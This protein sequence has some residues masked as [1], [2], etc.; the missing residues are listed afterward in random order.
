[1]ELKAFA[2]LATRVREGLA[3][4]PFNGIERG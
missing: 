1:M 2:E 3:Q 4:N